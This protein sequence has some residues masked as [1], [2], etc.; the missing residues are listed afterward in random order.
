MYLSNV[1]GPNRKGRPLGRQEDMVKEYVSGK[2]S[3]GKWVGVGKEGVYELGEVEVHLSWPPPLGD[4][5]RGNEVSE[6]LID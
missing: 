3:E 2:G 1:E 5:S 4:A 6:L